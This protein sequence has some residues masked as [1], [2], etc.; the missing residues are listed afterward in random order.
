MCNFFFTWFCCHIHVIYTEHFCL[1]IMVHFLVWVILGSIL[2]ANWAPGLKRIVRYLV[3]CVFFMAGRVS[4][5]VGFLDYDFGFL[6][7]F[8]FFLLFIRGSPFNRIRSFRSRI[9]IRNG[10]PIFPPFPNT[11]AFYGAYYGSYGF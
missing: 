7:L 9:R 5:P 2:H 11:P 4:D 10:T 1:S 6:F 3:F 8:F